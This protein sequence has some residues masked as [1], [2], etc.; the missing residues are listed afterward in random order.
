MAFTCLLLFFVSGAFTQEKKPFPL[1][2]EAS[3]PFFL[4]DQGFLDSYETNTTFKGT[5]KA[6]GITEIEEMQFQTMTFGWEFPRKGKILL[7][8]TNYSEESSDTLID[9]LVWNGETYLADEFY[10]PNPFDG[11]YDSDPANY[12]LKILDGDLGMKT[13]IFDV[14]FARG[15]G[16]GK[17]LGGSWNA[18]LRYAKHE[19]QLPLGYFYTYRDP[20][21]GF[22]YTFFNSVPALIDQEASFVGPKGGGEMHLF[23]FNKRL[24]LS[25]GADVSLTFGNVK[26][27]TQ[28]LPRARGSYD[29]DLNL[30]INY[31]YFPFSETR[32]KNP[33]FTTADF[34]IKF[35]ILKELYVFV[36]YKYAFFRD[37]FLSPTVVEL[38]T[39][40]DQVPYGVFISFSAGDVDYQTPYF[41]MSY[42]F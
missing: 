21:Y 5:G 16:K 3:F 41:G 42:Q 2:I 12:L 9:H 28:Y 33:F 24:I 14:A 4:S 15:F 38:P 30:V 18:G 29:E 32:S 31:E 26:V 37:V 23:L 19:Q 35:R 20:D 7:T 1:Y 17:R 40:T 10:D 11:N 22:S 6:L 36:G 8:Y 25:V 34:N 13:D 27:P 39:S